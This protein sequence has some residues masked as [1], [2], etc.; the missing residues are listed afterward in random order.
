MLRDKSKPTDLCHGFQ[1]ST[2]FWHDLV[3]HSKHRTYVVHLRL[4]TL[5]NQPRNKLCLTIP[6]H[7]QIMTNSIT[8]YNNWTNIK[9]YYHMYSCALGRDLRLASALGGSKWDHS[10]WRYEGTTCI[11]LSST[12]VYQPISQWWHKLRLKGL[13]RI[14]C[15]TAVVGLYTSRMPFLMFKQ[16]F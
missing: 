6:V 15:G 10:P 2:H 1:Y 4:Q 3:M 14:T 7:A 16:Q 11:L 8:H 5:L 9:H 13:L 12:F